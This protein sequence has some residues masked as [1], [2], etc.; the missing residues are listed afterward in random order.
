MFLDI[1][2]FFKEGPGEL[3]K[4]SREV[5][6]APNITKIWV[7]IFIIIPHRMM[8]AELSDFLVPRRYS[9]IQIFRSKISEDSQLFSILNPILRSDLAVGLK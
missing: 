5:C 8:F 4:N 9:M 3:T 6:G 7:K 2:D 1:I